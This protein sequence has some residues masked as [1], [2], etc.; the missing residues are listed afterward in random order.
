MVG[1]PT[2][3]CAI[4]NGAGKVRVNDDT[5]KSCW[6]SFSRMFS[7]RVGIAIASSRTL[8]SSPLYAP[9]TSTTPAV[10]LTKSNVYLTG[11][12]QDIMAHVKFAMIAK[13]LEHDLHYYMRLVTDEQLKSVYL[14]EMSYKSKKSKDRDLEASVS[15][16]TLSDFIGPDLHLAIIE[17]GTLGYPNRAMPGILKESLLI[18]QA[19]GKPTWIF[20]TPEKPWSPGHFSYNDDVCEYVSRYYKSINL[21]ELKPGQVVIPRNQTADFYSSEDGMSVDR[22]DVDE[23]QNEVVTVRPPAAYK[24]APKPMSA[25]EKRNYVKDNDLD[26]V[27][28]E[29]SFGKKKSKHSGGKNGKGGGGPI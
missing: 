6:C 13:Y 7:A 29:T 5:W 4:C 28:E 22:D 14:G 17:L 27:S 1:Q 3:T 21:T 11:W 25:H 24:P 8:D 18:R 26:I 20:D 15:Y 9:A 12:S 2:K 10:D 19:A 16:N 23:D